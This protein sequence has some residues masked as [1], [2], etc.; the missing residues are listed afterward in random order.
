[1]G[2]APRG[3]PPLGPSGSGGR[4]EALSAPRK[5]HANIMHPSRHD[6]IRKG[7]QC[8]KAPEVKAPRRRDRRSH[9]GRGSP[10]GLTADSHCAGPAPI[11]PACCVHVLC[12]P[13]SL[14]RACQ[15]TPRAPSGD[16]WLHEIKHDGCR[17]IAPFPA[18]RR[19]PCA[20][21]LVVLHNRRRGVA[22]DENGIAPFDRIRHHRHDESVFLYCLRPA[23]AERL[24]PTPRSASG[25]Q[26]H[27]HLW[28]PGPAPASGSTSTWKASVR[29]CSGTPVR[30]GLEGIVRKRKDSTYRSGR[31]PDWPKMKNPNAPAVACDDRRV[32][33]H[34]PDEV[35]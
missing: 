6:S 8:L 10:P 18:D 17:V 33:A 27:A 20:S 35:A 24:R 32:C 11:F 34:P 3:L 25:P 29:L 22:C 30:L 28:W 9:R 5:S 12:R 26:G 15:P 2:V 7:L 13:A 21:A 1:M 16:I 31:S 19:G 4:E 14:R 23:R